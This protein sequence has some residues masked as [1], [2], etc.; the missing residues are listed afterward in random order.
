MLEHPA[1]VEDVEVDDR[2]ASKARQGLGVGH[3]PG[4]QQ[5]AGALVRK[6]QHD[7]VGVESFGGPGDREL[8]V[9]ML[10][11]GRA[12]ADP[13]V[14]AR[15]LERDQRCV[16]VDPLKRG[17][18][19]AD[20]AGVG[21]LEQPDPEHECRGC[22]R[23]VPDA[24]V[25]CRTADQLPERLDRI[26]GLATIR[27]PIPEAPRVGGRIV[28]VD[29]AERR[30]GAHDR[31]PLGGLQ[32]SVAQQRAGEVER[33][34]QAGAPQPGGRPPG[35]EHRQLQAVL[36]HRVPRAAEALEQ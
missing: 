2:R 26:R 32:V 17:T 5:A 22:Q 23:C 15:G 30:R 25:E 35:S 16:T 14:D 10:D 11:R 21:A 31:N 3:R 4:R 7:R 28:E 19:I 34:G 24:Q 29:P 13:D 36:E 18:C 12:P 1:V 20:V 33:R 27:E 9:V 8:A 6:R